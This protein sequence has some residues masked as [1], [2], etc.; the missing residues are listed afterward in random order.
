MLLIRLLAR[1]IGGPIQAGNSLVKGAYK[2]YIPRNKPKQMKLTLTSLPYNLRYI[3][4][5]QPTTHTI[6]K[7]ILF[8]DPG[9]LYNNS[10]RNPSRDGTINWKCNTS[11]YIKFIYPKFLLCVWLG[12][13]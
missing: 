9:L 12:S 3:T 7:K 10:C 11:Q 13:P 4:N 1:P 5:I 6:K 2:E 8:W